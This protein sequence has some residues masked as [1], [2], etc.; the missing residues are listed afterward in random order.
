MARVLVVDDAVFMRR[1]VADAL[2]KGGHEVIGEAANGSEALQ[3]YQELRPE[4][5]TLDITMPEKDGVTTLREIMFFDPAA[6]VVMCSALGQ[7]S[8]V[9]EAIRA[10][11]KDFVVKPFEAER[12]Q[13]AVEKALA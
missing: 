13:T 9:L 5:T 7:E 4:V 11:A 1:M 10:G 2:T 8:K 3:Q 12:L 6:R